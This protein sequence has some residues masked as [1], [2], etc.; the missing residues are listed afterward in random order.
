M[1]NNTKESVL[2][3][4]VLPGKRKKRLIFYVAL[5]VSLISLVGVSRDTWLSF[6]YSFLDVS[7]EPEPADYIVVLAGFG[8][9]RI[10]DA[11]ELYRYGY[12]PRVI[13][14][15]SGEVIPEATQM[16][17]DAGIS[18]HALILEDRP[19]DSTW[20]EAH[21]ILALLNEEGAS[22]AI[23]VTNGWH[24]RRARAT[25]RHVQTTDE[26]E[27]TF[28]ASKWDVFPT[29][30]WWQYKWGR[31]VVRD[32]YIKLAAYLFRYGIVPI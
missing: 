2:E 4:G 9:H 16:F 13:I 17:E 10:P 26:I 28:V 19:G 15:G 24:T 6:L 21:R 30:P 14:S 18:P 3:T 11:I 32:E 31:V 25:Y 20:E 12:A 27:F 22:S 29:D 7:Q 23:I 1:M 5:F 8:T